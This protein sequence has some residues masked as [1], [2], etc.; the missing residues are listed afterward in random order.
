M[1]TVLIILFICL[2]LFASTFEKNYS[3]LNME[4]N[5]I[6]ANLSLEDRISLSYLILSTHETTTALHFT[7]EEKIQGLDNLEKQT[8][9]IL[10][11]LHKNDDKLNLQQLELIKELYV[12]MKE[13]AIKLVN[14]DKEKTIQ[15]ESPIILILIFCILTFF[16]GI[17]IGYYIFHNSYLRKNRPN[18][19]KF[20]IEDLENKNTNLEYK[21]ESLSALNNY[22]EEEITELIERNVH[23]KH[24]NKF[25]NEALIEVQNINDAIKNQ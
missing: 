9:K 20:I 5:K 14:S 16:I 11:Q 3:N 18:D 8:L 2:N 19:P 13:S 10:S 12:E 22:E 4:L 21:L 24:E 17:I 23:L 7:L 25:L 6:S 1:K 15:N